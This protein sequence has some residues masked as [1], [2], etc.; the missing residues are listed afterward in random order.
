MLYR[1]M[2]KNT[3][4]FN[5]AKIKSICCEG[6]SAGYVLNRPTGIVASCRTPV[7]R[8]YS[9][10]LRPAFKSTASIQGIF[11]FLTISTMTRACSRRY[12]FEGEILKNLA[13]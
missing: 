10:E 4:Y 2:N 5:E 9:G 6:H 13:D 3:G 7:I 8:A 12:A 11:F 1:I